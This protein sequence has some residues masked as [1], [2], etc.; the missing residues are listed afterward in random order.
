MQNSDLLL[1]LEDDD[2]WL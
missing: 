1:T 2:N